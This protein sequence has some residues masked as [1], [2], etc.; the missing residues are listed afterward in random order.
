MSL[1]SAF[2]FIS[3]STR[4]EQRNQNSSL[5]LFPHSPAPP[6]PFSVLLPFPSHVAPSSTPPH[7]SHPTAQYMWINQ[8]HFGDSSL[9]RDKDMSV[10]LR[11]DVLLFLYKDVVQKVPFFNNIGEKDDNRFLVRVCE[12][13][14]PR[15]YLPSD[16]II[17]EGTT[18]EEM[19]ILSKGTVEVRSQAQDILLSTLKPGCFFGEIS[20][21]LREKRT[22]SIKAKT[23]AEVSVLTA[24]VRGGTG[25]EGGVVVEFFGDFDFITAPRLL[26]RIRVVS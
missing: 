1:S 4:V 2:E 8:K 25:M 17:M 26:G 19:Y 14:R 3:Q 10:L 5:P 7:T 15:I 12:E 11:Q 16:F 18:G 13:L 22:A 24:T 9:L 6:V 23:I 21:I 20:L